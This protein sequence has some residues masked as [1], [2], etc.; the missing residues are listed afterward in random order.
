[1]IL[2][3]SF[4]IVLVISI[5]L[6]FALLPLSDLIIDIAR[7]TETR[8][9][10]LSTMK[11]KKSTKTPVNGETKEGNIPSENGHDEKKNGTQTAPTF[12]HL[13]DAEKEKG[14]F[15]NF[16]ISKKTIQKLKSKLGGNR[17]TT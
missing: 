9:N 1:M 5:D 10:P 3:F 17:K 12:I 13:S 15:Q 8:R 16:N 14:N 7:T 4:L 2:R 11:L 6:C